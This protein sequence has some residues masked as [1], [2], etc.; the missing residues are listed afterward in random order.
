ME[1]NYRANI[2]SFFVFFKGSTKS[3]MVYSVLF[4]V[5]KAPNHFQQMIFF[6]GKITYGSYSSL[7]FFEKL[8]RHGV[9][10]FIFYKI[11]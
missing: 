6:F 8:T 11:E 2:V 10:L 5:L 7:C 3:Y 1:F 9:F 4:L